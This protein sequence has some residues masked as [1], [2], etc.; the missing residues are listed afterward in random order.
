MRVC[1]YERVFVRDG[2]RVWV[3]VRAG[4]ERDEERVCLRKAECECVCL[5]RSLS[6]DKQK[7]KL[8]LIIIYF[9]PFF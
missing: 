4:L 5:R 1:V 8:N 2:E 3:S 7:K 6:D 9:S